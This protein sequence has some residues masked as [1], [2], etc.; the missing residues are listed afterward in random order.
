[1]VNFFDTRPDWSTTTTRPPTPFEIS[2]AELSGFVMNWILFIASAFL[3]MFLCSALIHHYM[4]HRQHE[5][6]SPS[7]PNEARCT[8]IASFVVP[9]LKDWMSRGGMDF[10]FVWSTCCF[11][12]ESYYMY[13]DFLCRLYRECYAFIVLFKIMQS[14]S[15]H[16]LVVRVHHDDIAT[17]RISQNPTGI[18]G[19]HA[20]VT[21]TTRSRETVRPEYTSIQFPTS[22]FRGQYYPKRVHDEEEFAFPDNVPIVLDDSCECR[23][24]IV[25]DC[26]DM[27]WEFT[28]TVVHHFVGKPVGATFTTTQSESESK[29]ESDA[30]MFS[31]VETMDWHPSPT[32]T[33]SQDDD[34]MDLDHDYD[35]VETMDWQPCPTTTQSQD[36]DSMM[37]CDEPDVSSL[38]SQLQDMNLDDDDDEMDWDSTV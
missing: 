18:V 23:T 19:H 12:L 1:M 37:D 3:V 32:T 38:L 14:S 22:K 16:D 8:S 9:A 33:S 36:E 17:V 7:E 21:V 20:T 2:L 35:D 31:A 25:D 15:F 26:N 24:K 11:V 6:H 13:L 29:S 10:G 30:G 34:P 28:P 27:D 5:R 4:I